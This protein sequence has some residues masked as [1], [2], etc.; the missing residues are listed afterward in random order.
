MLSVA[1]SIF[2]FTY[3]SAD[4]IDDS[5]FR[6]ERA[7][8]DLLTA[9][10]HDIEISLRSGEMYAVIRN[11]GSLVVA[12]G[13]QTADI[14]ALMQD[15][16][17]AAMFGQAVQPVP[18]EPEK[19]RKT[20]TTF[21]VHENMQ[22]GYMR[23]ERPEGFYPGGILVF[24]T[25]VDP[26]GLR[27][28]LA[29]TLAAGIVLMLAASILGGL[30]LARRS[31]EPVSRIARTA[32]AIGDGN[33]S[34]RIHLDTADELQEISDVFDDMLDR[35]EAAFMMQKRFV[36]DA[37]HE[38][39]TPLSILLLEADRAL[40]P[41]RTATEA[42]A[43]MEAMQTEGKYMARLVEDLLLLA[44]ADGNARQLPQRSVNLSGLVLDVVERYAPYAALYGTVLTIGELPEIVAAGD[45]NALVTVL[46][47]LV[48]NAIRHG[49]PAGIV[50][51][52]LATREAK[53]TSSESIITVTDQ[54]PGM[55]PEVLDKIF[56]RFYQADPSRSGSS[57]AGEVDGTPDSFR[58]TS[59]SGLGLSIVR[60][61]VI[62]HGGRIEVS[63]TVGSGSTFR[64]VLPAPDPVS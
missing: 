59:G 16:G 4:I 14:E 8:G 24:G 50:R 37:G 51:I 32:R 60:A 3:Q 29:A 15:I 56:D 34:Q 46:A 45:R 38:L 64:V 43:S 6:A 28:R 35:L 22:F 36:A 62:A 25:P 20:R 61:I 48:D 58:I 23:L 5:R 13:P 19:G 40:T 53:N 47:N 9:L 11:D 21:V 41:G 55:P 57:M 44:R 27:T 63:S 1:F 12:D 18:Y 42:R 10:D 2:V 49:I 26:Y 33:L 30:W 17:A 39:R 7:V 54:G 52:S 31:L